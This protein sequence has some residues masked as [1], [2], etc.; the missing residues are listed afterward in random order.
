MKPVVLIPARYNS[1]RFPGKP[2]AKIHGRP[3]ISI[4]YEESSK[5]FPTYVVTDSREIKSLFSENCI[6]VEDEVETGTERIA[7]AYERFLKEKKYDLIVNLQGD[8]ALINSS[9]LSDLVAFHAKKSS[10]SMVTVVRQRFG[11]EVDFNSPHVVKA[12]FDKETHTCHYFSRSPIPYFGKENGWFHHAGI[13]SFRPKVLED[14][15]LSH[16]RKYMA[17]NENLEQ[18]VVLSMGHSIGAIISKEE[19]RGVDTPSDI[20]YVERK[21]K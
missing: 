2:L 17:K 14:C 15:F 12:L 18:L 3:M 5:A 9:T 4:V 11:D 10:F 6:L 19:F 13:Y 16:S 21:L 7:L 1:T 20:E 8:E